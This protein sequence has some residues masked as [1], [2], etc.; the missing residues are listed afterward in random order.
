VG[1]LRT[2]ETWFSAPL[3]LPGLFLVTAIP[4][5]VHL[6]ATNGQWTFALAFTFLGIA[7]ALRADRWGWL[8]PLWGVCAIF[9]MGTGLVAAVGLLVLH[10]VLAWQWPEQ[11][12]RHAVSAALL[13]AAMGIWAIGFPGSDSQV[14]GPGSAQLWTHYFTLVAGGFGYVSRP[15]PALGGIA[16]LLLVALAGLRAATLGSSEPVDRRRWLAL[17]AWVGGLLLALASVSRARAWAGDDGALSGRY[18]FVALFLAPPFWLLLRWGVLARIQ[19]EGLRRAASAL[20]LV[21]LLLPLRSAF[22]FGRIY[23]PVEESRLR[24]VR[25]LRRMARAGLAPFCPDIQYDLELAP[26]HHR[27][28]VSL[29]LSYLGEQLDR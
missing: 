26:T 4:D 27:R 29:R 3:G 23:D 10:G 7:F 20:A 11:R 12:R 14:L 9:S 1:Y 5:E 21:V 25:C 24:G 13:V 16:V 8:S 15:L 2:L 6:H 18:L 19:P 22:D 28:A 17:L